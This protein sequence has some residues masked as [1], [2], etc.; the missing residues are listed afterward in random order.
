MHII[1]LQTYVKNI[2]TIENNIKT[3]L[4][5]SIET[6]QDSQNYYQFRIES[7]FRKLY[8]VKY[9]LENLIPKN[10][11]KRGLID[12]LGSIIKTITGNL[13][14][15]DYEQIS[16]TLDEIKQ[17][18]NTIYTT[19]NNNNHINKEM[20]ERFN[21]LQKYIEHYSIWITNETN[22]I[23]EK[24]LTLSNIIHIDQCIH[25]T[26]NKIEML[27]IHI[28]N[29]M[30]AIT[31]AKLKIISSH[32]LARNEINYIH[33]ILEKENVKL[34][35]YE[36]INE[37]L[38]LQA[39]YNKTTL[40]FSIKIPN[41]SQE[42]FSYYY[43]KLIPI[44]KT[45][46]LEEKPKSQ[47][48][49]LNQENYQYLT[50]PCIKIGNTQYCKGNKLQNI[51][52]ECIPR[53]LNNKDASC[54]L[55]KTTFE[56]EINQIFQNYIYISTINSIS[57][58]STCNQKTKILPEIALMKFNNCSIII[59]NITYNNNEVMF[60]E[61]EINILPYGEF[62]I[63]NTKIKLSLPEIHEITIDNNEQIKLLNVHHNNN[64][65]HKSA[66]AVTTLTI[67][68]LIIISFICIKIVR[69]RKNRMNQIQLQ[70]LTEGSATTSN[71]P[72]TNTVRDVRILRG[73][74]LRQREQPPPTSIATL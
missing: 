7:L 9:S 6:T 37:L 44:N 63:N 24:T 42:T 57:F 54:N 19:Y 69:L 51:K 11:N 3:L 31:F 41:F 18:E 43:I 34:N 62:K 71:I 61:K 15:N 33:T 45:N 5:F 49:I 14:Q 13:D 60:Y 20:L 50:N 30:E 64:M 29:I 47:Y 27:R 2:D 8:E 70:I 10:R 55:V 35:S 72:P 52:D 16:N 68:L 1:E 74:E 59:N 46:F 38:E 32:I 36:E 56:P 21:Y 12:G 67:T 40:I 17:N 25:I 22:K 66:F 28:K 39:Y 65:Y 73:E 53:I 4:Q 48:L 58:T 23:E 26:E